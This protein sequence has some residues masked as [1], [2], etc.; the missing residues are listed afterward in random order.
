MN[1]IR[2]IIPKSLVK[3]K[4][5]VFK[6]IRWIDILLAIL[7][8]AISIGIGIG[9]P[10][11]IFIRIIIIISIFLILMV[12]LIPIGKD[13]RRVYNRVIDIFKYLVSNKEFTKNGINKIDAFIPYEK[14][15]GNTVI[16]NK[17]FGPITY[18]KTIKVFGNDITSL[19]YQNQLLQFESLRDILKSVK[20]SCSLIKIDEPL[21][22]IKQSEEISLLIEKLENDFRNKSVTKKYYL[23][24]KLQ[25]LTQLKIVNNPESILTGVSNEKSFYLLIYGKTLEKVEEIASSVSD[26]LTSIN[27]VNEIIDK[28]EFVNLIKS[29][30]N[31]FSEKIPRS[32]V[33]D[34]LE[35]IPKIFDFEKLVFKPKNIIINDKLHINIS[36]V[37]DYPLEIDDYWIAKMALTTNSTMIWNFSEMNPN[38]AKSLINKAIVNSQSNVMS[39]NKSIEKKQQINLVESFEALAS[40]VA[41][42]QDE[43]KNSTLYFINYGLNKKGVDI[44]IRKLNEVLISM[45][46]VL[47]ELL[48][49][50]FEA[51]GRIIPR[52]DTNNKLN[53]IREI[54]LSTIAS[55]YPFLNNALL[56]DGGLLL[57]NNST[58]DSVVFNQFPKGNNMDRK[59]YNQ[60]LMGTSGSG[61]SFTVMKQ[62]NW[63]IANG[64]K[65][66][67]IDPEREYKQLCEYYDGVWIDSSNGT[68]NRINPLQIL[69][70]LDDSNSSQNMI[71]NHIQLLEHFFS[72]IIPGISYDKLRVISIVLK[73]LYKKFK[74][75]E[76]NINK[77]EFNEFPTFTDFCDVI[78]DQKQFDYSKIGCDIEDVKAVKSIFNNDFIN[79][80]KYSTLYNGYSNIAVEND[81]VVFD[82]NALFEKGSQNI[83]QAQLFLILAFVQNIV[84]L[85]NDSNKEIIIAI[86]EAHLLIDKDNPVA[87]NFMFQM[88]KRI[89]KRNGGIIIITQNP[90]DFVGTE[91]IRKKTTAMINNTQYMFLLNMSP[92]NLIDISEMFKAYGDGLSDTEKGFIARAKR[93]QGLFFVTGFNRHMT[94]VRH[95]PEEVI[96]YKGIPPELINKNFSESEYM[97]SKIRELEM[98]SY[99]KYNKTKQITEHKKVLRKN[100][101]SINQDLLDQNKKYINSLNE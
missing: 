63:H 85:N 56:D 28:Y 65:V 38:I 74:V 95:A 62:L 30:F 45:G 44:D 54:P 26:K 5:I 69:N 67:I 2:N 97:E 57:G 78:N 96:A 88:V 22:L 13:S 53:N 58:G 34:N 101:K 9:I 17:K 60:L 31:P 84:R 64:R 8:L 47:D 32:I 92:K 86:D 99:K 52:I 80:G 41:S 89:R 33:D 79:D 23:A 25:L 29:L 14:F 90:D 91:E 43:L 59:N 10:V 37:N 72:I 46:I 51:Y 55:G 19:D 93:G 73:V 83:I 1:S 66:I 48:F 68:V 3:Q 70:S 94:S 77:M 20:S 7:F 4:N 40:R 12:M 18:I 87:L 16:T 42:S 49:R 81:M 100:K 98:V 76:K 21:Q 82:I 6:S 71:E 27:L 35:N 39:I 24:A 11:S 36:T 15:E 75:N 61:K 50:Q